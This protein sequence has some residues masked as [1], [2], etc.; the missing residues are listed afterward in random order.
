MAG[1]FPRPFCGILASFDGGNDQTR[2]E[3]PRDRPTRG[4]EARQVAGGSLDCKFVSSI[5]SFVSTRGSRHAHQL[6]RK[7]SVFCEIVHFDL[8]GLARQR[9]MRAQPSW[10]WRQDGSAKCHFD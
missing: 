4:S 8:V 10:A 2:G 9:T 1:R 6:P 7:R 3:P 5:P